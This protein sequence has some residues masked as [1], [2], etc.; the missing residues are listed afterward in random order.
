MQTWFKNILWVGFLVGI[1]ALLLCVKNARETRV[2][3]L[4]TLEIELIDDMKFLTQENLMDRLKARGLVADSMVYSQSDIAEIE[5]F[6]R[7][8]PEVKSVQA[9][10]YI[11]GEWVIDVKLRKPLVR[12]FNRDGSS[13]YLDEDGTL[14]PLSRNYAAHVITVNGNINETDYTKTVEDIMNNDSLK[15]NEILDDLYAISKYVCSDEFSSAQVTHIYIN[16]YDEFEFIP[17]VGDQRIM[18]GDASHVE[19]KMKKLEWFYTEGMSRSGWNQYDTINI[20]YKSQVVC[21]SRN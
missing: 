8:M 2:I 12:I 16:K 6:V 3:G 4:P 1:W 11:S 17:R 7:E 18:F 15:T 9:Y 21:S 20:M 14:M 19:G 10:T 5:V 13:C